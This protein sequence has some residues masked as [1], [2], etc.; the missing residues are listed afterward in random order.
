[1]F[2]DPWEHILIPA[3][4]M[5]SILALYYLEKYRDK[6]VEDWLHTNKK[7]AHEVLYVMSWY[8]TAISAAFGFIGY[9]LIN[10]IG[11]GGFPVF[12]IPP[13]VEFQFIV[14]TST[15]VWSQIRQVY[16]H[17]LFELVVQELPY[18][19]EDEDMANRAREIIMQVQGEM[20][21]FDD[22]VQEVKVKLEST[23]KQQK[24]LEE[25]KREKQK[26]L[27]ETERQIEQN[28]YLIEETKKANSGLDQFIE[29]TK[30]TN[31][32]TKIAFKEAM[33][34]FRELQTMRQDI[35]EKSKKFQDEVDAVDLDIEDALQKINDEWD[36]EQKEFDKQ[37]PAA[38]ANEKKIRR[39][40]TQVPVLNKKNAFLTQ[41][42]EKQM[43]ELPKASRPEFERAVM[44][45][46]HK[47]LQDYLICEECKQPKR[48]G[49][50][51]G[52]SGPM[53]ST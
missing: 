30:A 35:L 19:L 27:S 24:E 15:L 36:Q 45:F 39:Y 3:F 49:C 41:L 50:T 51:C 28:N 32:I 37:Y 42:L 20:E 43:K 34:K 25:K 17:T 13:F 53:F 26:Y 5:V 7:M 11:W 33:K 48:D 14:L 23:T 38:D 47:K 1:M 9:G 10:W 8:G 21:N 29:D 6:S 46:K 4:G 22:V 40:L 2:Y 44:D 18:I 31:K 52:N 12:D 16:S